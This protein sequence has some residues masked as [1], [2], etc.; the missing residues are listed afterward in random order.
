MQR[1]RSGFTLI[2]LLVVVA[3]IALLISI[4]LPSLG[5]ARAQAKKT[6]CASNLHQIGIALTTYSVE[7]NNDL[8]VET[9]R[10]HESYGYA[11]GVTAYH[12]MRRGEAGVGPYVFPNGSTETT[13]WRE[14][15]CMDN[16]IITDPRVYYCP[17]QS[18][19]T[20]SYNKPASSTT[21][22]YD[23]LNPIN[24]HAGY[25][26]QLHMGEN[27]THSNILVTG[28]AAQNVDGTFVG[29]A[30]TKITQ[31]P[32]DLWLM[33]DKIYDVISIP[34]AN[35]SGENGLFGDA[36]VEFGSNAK[37]KTLVSFPNPYGGQAYNVIYLLEGS[38][39]KS[40]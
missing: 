4:L 3:I 30:Y 1:R 12:Y 35:N 26:Y 21:N 27:P 28:S 13:H 29:A 20:W 10:H 37:V 16:A 8:P 24:D 17:G 36:H 34:H 31:M 15:L 18:N 5:R 40:K 19:P 2:E 9:G 11:S 22:P 33:S 23:F 38:A 7:F 32:K 14:L 25:Q 39:M 6:A